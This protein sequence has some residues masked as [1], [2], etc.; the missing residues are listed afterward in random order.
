ML[1]QVSWERVLLEEGQRDDWASWKRGLL[2]GLNKETGGDA[3][4]KIVSF[5]S[6]SSPRALALHYPR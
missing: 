4:S 2:L 1:Y 5:L 3:G 6:G